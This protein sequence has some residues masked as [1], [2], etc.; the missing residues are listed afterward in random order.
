[1]IWF[2]TSAGPALATEAVVSG[3]RRQRFRLGSGTGFWPFSA[4]TM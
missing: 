2:S 3:A 1:M 4:W